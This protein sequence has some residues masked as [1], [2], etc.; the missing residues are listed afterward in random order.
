MKLE[1]ANQLLNPGYLP[2]ETGYCRLPNGQMHIAALNPMYKCNSDWLAWYFGNEIRGIRNFKEL[3]TAT[4][5][6]SQWDNNKWK[7]VP[8][9]DTTHEGEY[10]L[11][12]T[13]HRFIIKYSDPS[14]FL[15]TS[16]FKESKVGAIVCA[17]TFFPDGTPEGYLIHIVRDT[18]DGCEM[19]TRFWAI[20][21]TEEIA[22]LQVERFVS[23]FNRLPSTL[24]LLLGNTDIL[25]N[26]ENIVCKF[27]H[28]NNIV[29]NGTRKNVQ[30]WLCKKCHRSF[31]NN[32][33]LPKMQYPTQTIAQAVNEYFNGNSLNNIRREIEITTKTLP[34][35]STLYRWILKLTETARSAVKNY[36]PHVSNKWIVDEKEILVNG[37][38]YSFINV[39]DRETRF[40]LATKLFVGECVA[41]TQALL[42]EAIE[43]AG[44]MPDEII[45]HRKSSDSI[46]LIYGNK[47]I[48]AREVV[49]DEP[50][51]NLLS[52]WYSMALDRLKPENGLDINTGT[53]TIL[54]GF[55]I[56]YN[57]IK[58][59]PDIGKTPSQ[60]SGIQTSF[61]S[62]FDIAYY[63]D[64]DDLFSNLT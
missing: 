63:A 7:T 26:Q 27:C 49:Y 64:H 21:T 33:A 54:E 18:I 56:H 61:R 25:H 24:R 35:I 15:D 20:N 59:H 58:L 57:Y 43:K 45:T 32:Y 29:K 47:I 28:S 8:Y 12:G 36:H 1:E 3:D 23:T 22:K 50:S 42:A 48:P 55:A 2:L 10:L 11:G 52:I 9:T 6:V 37:K 30:Y 62:W 34:S 39:M 5:P 41:N 53:E 13:L 19:R 51:E 44:K 31:V 14:K 16:K 40:L 17:E 60:A 46:A 4:T 38:I